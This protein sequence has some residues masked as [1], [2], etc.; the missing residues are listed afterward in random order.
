MNKEGYLKAN[1]S[2]LN[3][4]YIRVTILISVFNRY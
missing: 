1:V 2:I 4:V 3:P